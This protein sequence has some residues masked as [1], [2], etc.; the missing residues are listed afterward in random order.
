MQVILSESV[1]CPEVPSNLYPGKQDSVAVLPW[2]G[3]FIVVIFPK[4]GVLRP[5]QY[6]AERHR[7]DMCWQYTN[8]LIQYVTQKC[9]PNMLA[10]KNN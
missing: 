4:A 9:M 7:I 10:C 5:V 3:A 1:V 2:Y 6:A 8:Q